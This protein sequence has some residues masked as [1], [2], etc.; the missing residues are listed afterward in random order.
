MACEGQTGAQSRRKCHPARFEAI[1]G[2]H[3]VMF[4]ADGEIVEITHKGGAYD[5][6]AV[7]CVLR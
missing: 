3:T 2:D 6:L 1:V 4:I 5:P 7:R